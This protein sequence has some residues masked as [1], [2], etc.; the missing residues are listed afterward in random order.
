M[1]DFVILKLLSK[2]KFLPCCYIRVVLTI[3]NWGKVCWLC[4]GN[5]CWKLWENINLFNM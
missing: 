5:V 2:V 1:S 3:R 4:L